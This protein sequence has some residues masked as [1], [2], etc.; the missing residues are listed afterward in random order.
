MTFI[1]TIHHICSDIFQVFEFF[2]PAVLLRIT[3]AIFRNSIK[4][5]VDMCQFTITAITS[6]IELY[7][8]H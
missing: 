8:W 1:A 2:L 5:S 7:F 4:I 6:L 3:F